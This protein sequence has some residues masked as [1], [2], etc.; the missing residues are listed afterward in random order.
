[1]IDRRE[2]IERRGGRMNACCDNRPV[3]KTG[4]LARRCL[5]IAACAVP[6]VLLALMPKC[7]ACLVAYI[8]FWTGLGLSFTTASYLRTALLVLCVASL[9]YLVVTRLGR[10][11]VAY[12]GITGSVPKRRFP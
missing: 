4:S 3:A 7:P 2:P 10:F 12:G 6:S 11:R 1:M 8:A 9:L 5:D